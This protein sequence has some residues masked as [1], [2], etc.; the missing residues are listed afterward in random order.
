MRHVEFKDLSIIELEE[1]V[2]GNKAGEVYLA[3]LGCATRGIKIGSSFGGWG[4]VAGGVAG[5]LICGGV[6]YYMN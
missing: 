6:T 4:A 3:A 1:S 5:A 2:G